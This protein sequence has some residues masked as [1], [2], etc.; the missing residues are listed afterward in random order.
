MEEAS[1]N[2]TNDILDAIYGGKIRIKNSTKG[3]IVV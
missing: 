1:I 3:K 2:N